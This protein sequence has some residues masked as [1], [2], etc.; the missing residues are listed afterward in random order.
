MNEI[1][2]CQ[3][4]D[5][6]EL[7]NKFGADNLKTDTEGQAVNWMKI[8]SIKVEKGRP[9]EIQI[10]ES[11]SEPYMVIKLDRSVFRETRRKNKLGP[12]KLDKTLLKP[13]YKHVLP[14]SKA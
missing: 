10:K 14:V 13:A 9:D 4:Y 11:Y 2:A 7:A 6:R 5:L 1:E 12:V 8:K 3:I